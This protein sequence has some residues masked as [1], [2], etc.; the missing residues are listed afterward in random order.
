MFFLSVESIISLGKKAHEKICAEGEEELGQIKNSQQKITEK[1]TQ[2]SC[3][4]INQSLLK[5]RKLHL[6]IIPGQCFF[7]I[8]SESMR[9]SLVSDCF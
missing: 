1:Y 3:F 7:P 2:Q 6:Q 8:S 9:K 4:Q 5:I